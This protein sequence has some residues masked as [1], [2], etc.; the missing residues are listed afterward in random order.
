MGD[1]LRAGEACGQAAE[2]GGSEMRVRVEHVHPLAPEEGPQ[3]ECPAQLVEARAL[4]PE[5]AEALAPREVDERPLR[6][7]DER[8]VVP[9]PPR[10]PRQLERN[11]LSAGDVAARDEVEDP[12]GSVLRHTATSSVAPSSRPG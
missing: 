6:W 3:C 2:D 1:D 8:D 11:E 12:H 9:P 4:D 10:G 5:A 7:R